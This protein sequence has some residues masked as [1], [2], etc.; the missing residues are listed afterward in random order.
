MFGFVNVASVSPSSERTKG[1]WVVRGLY[2]EQWSK[3][4][5]WEHGAIL[6][7]NKNK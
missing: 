4:I 1:L 2:S 7:G 3:V 5:W 6:R